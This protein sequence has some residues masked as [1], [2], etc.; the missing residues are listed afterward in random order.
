MS[1]KRPHSS[2]KNRM[3][4]SIVLMGGGLALGCGGVTK[5]DADG[6][7][8]SS[9]T[10]H[11]GASS[12]PGGVT[13][14]GGSGLVNSGG[15]L[16]VPPG[17]APGYAG[18]IGA[19]GTLSVAGSPSGGGAAGGG[20][21]SPLPCPPAQWTCATEQS[22]PPQGGLQL[23]TD[24]TCDPSRPTQAADCKGLTFVC[25][26]AE[27]DTQGNPLS[28]SVPYECSCLPAATTAGDSCYAACDSAYGAARFSCSYGAYSPSGTPTDTDILCSC[29]T[30]VV[31]K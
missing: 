5:S 14:T 12:S 23:G 29:V 18:A 24:C 10:T 26:L 9:A 30:V 15:S 17:G 25:I 28:A 31:L 20:F 16:I 11:G 4:N 1:S 27:R 7:A 13:S 21:I 2:G 3:F 22:C 19:G 8:G 6:A